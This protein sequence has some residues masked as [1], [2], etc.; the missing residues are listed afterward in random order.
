MRYRALVLVFLLVGLLGPNTH[1]VAAQEICF[2]DQPD[3]TNCL[4]DTFALFWEA[5]GGLPVFGYPI[6][7]AQNEQS[8]DLDAEL[9]TQWTERY[10]LEFHPNNEAPYTILLGRMGAE[11]LAQIGRNP[12]EE[13]REDGP[14]PDC[15][16]FEETGH[17]VC[18]Q[19]PG[20][21]FRT[22]WESNGLNI[23]GLDPYNQ[24]LQLFGLPLTAAQEE[25]N[26]SGDT[27]LTQWFERARL[28]WHPDNPDEFKVLLG[29]LG[30]EVQGGPQGTPGGPSATQ[31]SIFGVEINR[32]Q[33]AAVAEQTSMT[34]V[35]LV[36]YNA[37]PWNQVEAT[38][39]VRD[40]SRLSA[41]EADLQ[42]LANMGVTPMVI[43]SMA[44]TWAQ[45]VPGS[46]CG[47]IKPEALSAFAD[48]LGEL[49]TR[50]SAAPYNVRYWE[51]GNEPDVDPSLVDGGSPFGCW[52][53]Q[54][55]PYYGGGYYAE[56]LKAVYPAM[57]QADPNAQLIIGGLL[58]DCDPTN[59]PGWSD[60]KS[61]RFLEGILQNGGGDFLDIVAYHA[62]TYWGP[63]VADWDLEHP[64]W[65]HRGGMLLGKLDFIRA[66]MS[67]YGVDKPVIMNEG[68][69]LCY[70]S[71]VSCQDVDGTFRLDQA[72]YAV[73]MYSRA[74]ANGLLGAVWYTMNGPGWR[75]GGL[76]DGDQ[77]P[78]PAYT[79]LQFMS[80]RLQ[81]ATFAESL[82]NETLEGYAF[83]SSD[84]TYHVYWT[85]DASFVDVPLPEGTRSVYDY[86]GSR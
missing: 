23:S 82:T 76:L 68:G 4:A 37:F 27:V 74:W 2:P 61:A 18:D 84:A 1:P 11:R 48:F 34:D 80:N 20:R 16:W 45:L 85:N 12:T 22:Y 7:A 14:L 57:K 62:Y 28:E 69:L 51:F 33:V 67:Q 17:N 41:T 24:S 26:D 10:R 5:N 58:L 79:T 63:E 53:D 70:P 72:N 78:R 49:V 6:T 13:G 75:D 36:R 30:T 52:G 40:W 44:P 3:V 66:L 42:T 60:C 43:V 54:D 31:Q 73:R 38:Q 29:L 64:S 32:G 35:A 81:N 9:F 47:P 83:T 56:M 50:Y 15:V 65:K 8:A 25:T 39:G 86:L 55:D 21:G 19:E 46:A 71:G 59:P 77:G